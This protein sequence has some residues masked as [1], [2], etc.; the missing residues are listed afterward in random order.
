MTEPAQVQSAE[1]RL[2]QI[3]NT[4]WAALGYPMDVAADRQKKGESED[5]HTGGSD[6]SGVDWKIGGKG[7]P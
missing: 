4:V 2:A 5:F 3:N 1:F 6:C 7:A